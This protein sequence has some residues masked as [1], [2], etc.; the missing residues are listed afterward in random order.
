M[1]GGVVTSFLLDHGIIWRFSQSGK[2]AVYQTSRRTFPLARRPGRARCCWVRRDHAGSQQTVAPLK[3]ARRERAED[4]SGPRALRFQPPP[5]S[6]RAPDRLLF[7]RTHHAAHATSALS[8]ANNIAVS[9]SHCDPVQHRVEPPIASCGWWFRWLGSRFARSD[10]FQNWPRPCWRVA[11][12]LQV[13]NA[14]LR[15]SRKQ[16]SRRSVASCAARSTVLASFQSPS[17][18]CAIASGLTYSQS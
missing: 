8:K 2:A 12:D 18:S 15:P 17:S 9:S 6:L 5:K 7:G 1:I 4:C 16:A 14:K 3:Y 10:A 13:S 11:V